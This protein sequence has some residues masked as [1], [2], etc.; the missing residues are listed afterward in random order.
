MPNFDSSRLHRRRV[1]RRT[2][3][4]KNSKVLY[5]VGACD[6]DPAQD[7]SPAD[8]PG[9]LWDKFREGK[10]REDSDD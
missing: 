10:I 6:I 5:W 7:I 8:I 9:A 3:S 2:S 1:H 4:S